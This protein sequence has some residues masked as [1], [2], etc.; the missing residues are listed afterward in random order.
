M[1]PIP[2][3]LP[4]RAARRWWPGGCC[5]GCAI[6]GCWWRPRAGARCGRCPSAARGDSFQTSFRCDDGT[7]RYQVEI[8]GVGGRAR[9]VVANFPVSLRGGAAAG[10]AR[11]WPSGAPNPT[12]PARPSSCCW[13]SVNRDRT[14]AGSAGA[15]LGRTAGPGCPGLQRRDGRS[16]AGGPRLAPQR[17]RRRPR[18]P[19]GGAGRHRAGERRPRQ[20]GRR[21]PEEL[22]VQP[23]PPGQRAV[24][25]GHPPGRRRRP[26]A[27]NPAASPACTSPSCSRTRRA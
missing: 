27:R 7:G 24:P 10:R 15:G 8:V 20:L 19:R 16:P 22:H 6:P 11:A 17:Q 12:I 4:T 13:Q 9:Q 14:A 5:A 26:S 3:R 18:A 21:R 1:L 25:Q 23:R 2:R